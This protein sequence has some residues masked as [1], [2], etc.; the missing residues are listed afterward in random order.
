[1]TGRPLAATLLAFAA[2]AAAQPYLYGLTSTGDLLSINPSTG[3]ATLIGST[4]LP[5]LGAAGGLYDWSGLP[6]RTI[7][8]AIDGPGGPQLVWINRFTAALES[9]IPISGISAGYHLRAI[10]P[11]WPW[12]YALLDA[13]DPAQNDALARIDPLTGACS[14]VCTTDRADLL[15]LAYR[16][17]HGTFFSIG[18][19]GGGVLYTFPA[20]DG[21]A[22]PVGQF[23]F[24]DNTALV[25]LSRNNLLI[26]GENLLSTDPTGGPVTLIGPTGFPDIRAIATIDYG[27]YANCDHGWTVPFLNALDF[28]CFLN[29]FAAGD[30]YANC[31]ESTTP[32]V[33]NVLDFNCFL[34]RFSAGCSA[35]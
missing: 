7:V 28:N 19:T 13:D 20:T 21:I 18:A 14:E 8:A 6:A 29:S 3:S 15:S 2:P 4:G 10:A 23:R 11:G 26:G 17:S 34:N 24:G 33:L 22:Y 35:P 1:M 31:D 9:S 12:V 5:I 16:P 32:P 25:F 30:P 27:C